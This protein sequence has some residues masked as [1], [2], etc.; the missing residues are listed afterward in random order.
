MEKLESARRVPCVSAL[1]HYLDMILFFPETSY[2]CHDILPHAKEGFGVT[3]AKR[4]QSRNFLKQTPRKLGERK[5]GIWFP[6]AFPAGG[7]PAFGGRGD[8]C[9]Y[10]RERVVQSVH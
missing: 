2:V 3:D 9:V 8:P 6:L 10:I 4:S 1:E 5:V 7:G